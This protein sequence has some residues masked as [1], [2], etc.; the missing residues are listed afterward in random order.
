MYLFSFS[1]M[2]QSRSEPLSIV[3]LLHPESVAGLLASGGLN[4]EAIQRLKHHFAKVARLLKNALKGDE[5]TAYAF[6]VPGRI[7]VLGKHVDYAGGSSLVCTLQRGFCLIAAPRT[8]R[9]LNVIHVETGES[10][11]FPLDDSL[12]AAYGHWSNY[13]MTVAR[14]IARNFPGVLRG[15]D[16]AFFSDLPPASGMSSS[17]A[18]MIAFF[19]SLSAINEL[20]ARPEYRQNI[21]SREHLAHYLATIENGQTYGT[22]AGDKG[23]GTFGGSQDH[24]AI[25]CSAPNR[26]SKFAYAP[27]CFERSLPIPSKYVFVIGSSGVVA[28]K[29]GKA[30]DAYNRASLL[31]ARAGQAWNAVTGRDDPHLAAAVSSPAFSPGAMNQALRDA[32][33]PDFIAEDL[34]NRFEQFF[35]ENQVIVPAAVRAI[36]DNDMQRFG[37]VVDRSQDLAERLLKNQTDETIFLARQARQLGAVASSA[38][39]A[40]FGGSVWALVAKD[41]ARTMCT[42]WR[43]HYTEGFPE[44]AQRSSFFIDYAGPAAFQLGSRSK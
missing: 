16:I 25:L 17:S 28:N 41:Q 36:K 3:S 13:P 23:V 29:T 40:G 42:R 44:P 43:I 15:A 6:W 22:L 20:P 12:T 27:T 7:E 2:K 11:T 35:E 31:A 18:F 33:D 14:R 39:G 5:Q 37:E 10:V 32:E 24:T 1:M 9:V 34:I 21:W 26:I 19:L 4:H 8:D 38:F 30:R